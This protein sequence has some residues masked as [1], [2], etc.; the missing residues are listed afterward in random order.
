ME[1]GRERK[2]RERKGERKDGVKKEEEEMEI[3]GEMR[4]RR[5]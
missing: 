4:K 1:E 5:E 2:G 3:R